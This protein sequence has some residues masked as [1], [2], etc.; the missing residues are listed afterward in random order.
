M[1]N[2]RLF[3]QL[4]PNLARIKILKVWPR[5]HSRWKIPPRIVFVNQRVLVRATSAVNGAVDLYTADSSYVED[6]KIEDY[7]RNQRIELSI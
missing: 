5:H 1:A 6:S 4:I 2:I 3:T 7:R